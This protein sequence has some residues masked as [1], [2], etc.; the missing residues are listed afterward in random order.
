M[1]RRIPEST[2]YF[3]VLLNLTFSHK[4]D[5]TVR[6]YTLASGILEREILVIIEITKKYVSYSARGIPPSH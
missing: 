2:Y 3:K 1:F 4:R 6:Y 5:H